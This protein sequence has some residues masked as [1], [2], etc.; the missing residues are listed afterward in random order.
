MY[1]SKFTG[2]DPNPIPGQDLNMQSFPHLPQEIQKH[3]VE[4]T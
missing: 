2:L 1:I 3:K 4:R